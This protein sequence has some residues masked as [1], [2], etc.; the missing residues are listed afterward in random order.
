M[1]DDGTHQS[2]RPTT[3]PAWKGPL[4]WAVDKLA[5]GKLY[6]NHS[7]A[8]PPIKHPR[9]YGL[10]GYTTNHLQYHTDAK[11]QIE[12]WERPAAGGKSFDP[13]H[14]TYV[15]YHGV[16]GHWGARD[17]FGHADRNPNHRIEW[18]KSLPTDVN[19]I[20]VSMPEF[21]NS[22]GDAD[23]TN[24]EAA[25]RAVYHYLAD[26]KHIRPE[27]IIAQGESMG[28]NHAL[29]F[30]RMAWQE[31]GHPIKQVAAIVPFSDITDTTVDFLTKKPTKVQPILN[32]LKDVALRPLADQLLSNHHHYDNTKEIA[33]LAGSGT[34]ILM[35]SAGAEKKLSIPWQQNTLA[36]IAAETRLCTVYHEQSGAEHSTWDPK[37]VEKISQ[38]MQAQGVCKAD[39]DVRDPKGNVITPHLEEVASRGR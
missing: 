17:T 28:A 19:V 39:G 20:A 8:V 24:F 35:V 16:N 36:V 6:I 22:T 2:F 7:K 1:A 27:T 23:R 18:L 9:E 34:Q 26:D 11:Y 21:G 38:K 4:A 3:H 5:D 12:V 29:R 30:A 15:M 10:E 33:L 14:P 32:A 37:Q 13:G 31:F 25:T